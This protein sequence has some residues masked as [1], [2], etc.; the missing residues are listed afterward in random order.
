MTGMQ[1]TKGTILVENTVKMQNEATAISGGI[2][3]GDT[4]PADDL[5]I[6]LFPGSKLSLETG[7]LDYQNTQ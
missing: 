1:L 7:Y 2:V 5:S 6:V 4:I 3:F